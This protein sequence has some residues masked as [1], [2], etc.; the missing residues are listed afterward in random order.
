MLDCDHNPDCRANQAS[1]V[2]AELAHELNSH[3]T[4]CPMKGRMDDVEDFVISTQATA[5]ANGHWLSRLWPLIYAV[6]GIV[7]YRLLVHAPELLR[8]WKP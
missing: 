3:I 8:I 6:A 5:S 2:K 7:G 4:G 1:E